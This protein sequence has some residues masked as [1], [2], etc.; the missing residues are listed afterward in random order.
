MNSGSP[1]GHTWLYYVHIDLKPQ[2]VLVN[3]GQ[4]DMRFKDVQLSNWGNSAPAYEPYTRY[5]DL[6]GIPTWRSFEAHLRI[7]W[8]TPTDV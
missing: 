7:G 1:G 6:I 2:N 4:G 8:G 3:Y 5:R